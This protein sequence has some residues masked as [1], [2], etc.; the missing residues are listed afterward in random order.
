M[1]NWIGLVGSAVTFAMF[2]LGVTFKMGQHSARIDALEKSTEDDRIA[3]ERVTALETWRTTMRDDMHEI[4]DKWGQ[5]IE[6]MATLTTLV[7]ERT[8][9]RYTDRPE[10]RQLP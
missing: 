3:P 2:V 9:R 8:D 1:I 7:R 6:Q 4:S 5:V 10:G